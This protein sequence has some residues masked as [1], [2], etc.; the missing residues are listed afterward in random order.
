MSV[1]AL[2]EPVSADDPYGPDLSEDTSRYVLTD[3]FAG[4]S[5]IDPVTGAPLEDQ[6]DWRDVA[7]QVRAA[8]KQSKDVWL[9]VYLARAGARAGNLETVVD[10]TEALARLFE[11]HWD[12]VHPRIEE[13]GLLGRKSPCDELCGLGTFLG[14]LAAAPLMKHQRF[15]TFSGADLARFVRDGANAE[16]Y[17][18]F[19]ALLSEAGDAPLTEAREQLGRIV[20][21]LRRAE[22]AF[23]SHASGGPS[24]RMSPAIDAVNRMIEDAGSFLSTPAE[25]ESAAEPDASPVAGAVPAARAAQGVG[26]ISSRSDVTKALDLIMTY[27]RRAEPSSP[28]LLLIQRAREWVDLDFLALVKDMAPKAVD[29]VMQILMSDAARKGAVETQPQKTTSSSGW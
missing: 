16:N 20:D 7:N 9:A 10:A 18:M 26:D 29:D 27:Y 23:D 5:G 2:L 17:G 1:E 24:P 21:A 25:T 28:V 14:P 13:L 6:T 22:T 11:D 3:L 19:R 12:G 8:F 15:G 4:S